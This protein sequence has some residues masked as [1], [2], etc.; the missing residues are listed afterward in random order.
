[1]NHQVLDFEEAL[2]G[3][4]GNKWSYSMVNGEADYFL[5]RGEMGWIVDEKG[6]RTSHFQ[7]PFD[8]PHLIEN[9]LAA[10]AVVRNFK[11][12]WEEILPQIEKLQAGRMRFEKME[13]GGVLFIKDMYNAN[14][15]AMRMTLPFLPKPAAGG[16]RIGVLGAMVGLGRFS[17][18]SHE[19]V[20]KTA[21]DHLDILLC[22][23]KE[24]KVMCD[25]FKEAKKP[26]QLF[27]NHEHLS[28]KL[29]E[30]IRPGDVVFVKGSRKMELEKIFDL[31]TI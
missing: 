25:L 9:F 6:V 16:K 10:V 28:R 20:G 3:F 30:W 27:T 11:M 26:A 5:Q 24:C 23:G 29:Q 1:M 2:E 31:M 4:S 22:I 8:A 19:Q 12:E 15:E 14:P 18:E 17:K 7:L 21:L 13:K